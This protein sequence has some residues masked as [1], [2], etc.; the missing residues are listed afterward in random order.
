MYDACLE[1][2]DNLC[3]R[4]SI[5]FP[6]LSAGW[7]DI[8]WRKPL[9]DISDNIWPHKT[10]LTPAVVTCHHW[11]RRL[12][13]THVTTRSQLSV[14]FPKLLSSG[15]LLSVPGHQSY[16]FGNTNEWLKWIFKNHPQNY[17]GKIII[18][19]FSFYLH[20][21]K[22]WWTI[23]A[24]NKEQLAKDQHGHICRPPSL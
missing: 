9:H 12:P 20:I 8:M 14:C 7:L 15:D 6:V 24:I 10:G 23:A 13:C 18:L 17:S 2:M 11:A 16:E 1:F 5:L 19:C 21:I 3:T 4:V 22:R